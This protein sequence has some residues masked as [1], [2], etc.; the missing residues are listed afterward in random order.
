[1][2]LVASHRGNNGLILVLLQLKNLQNVAAGMSQNPEILICNWGIKL[3]MAA[4]GFPFNFNDSSSGN[5]AL[6]SEG[7][8]V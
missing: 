8:M 2:V 4:L 6:R 7:F 5:R 1:M 3:N